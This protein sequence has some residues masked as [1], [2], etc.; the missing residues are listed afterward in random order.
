M[1]NETTMTMVGNLTADPRMRETASGVK[2]ANF[3]VAATPRRFDREAGRYVDHDSLFLNVTCWRDL[4][5][6]VVTSL[7]KGDPVIVNGRMYTRQYERN[8]QTQQVIEM[9]ATSVGP[10]LSKG[11]APFRRIRTSLPSREAVAETESQAEEESPQEP[12]LEPELA[13]AAL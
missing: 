5:E 6:N 3:R 11:V 8:E 2:V 12:A 1:Y 13:G 7:H 10:D 9:E 4:A